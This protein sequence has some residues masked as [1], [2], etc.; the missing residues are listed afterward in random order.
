MIAQL[1]A[2]IADDCPN[3]IFSANHIRNSHVICCGSKKLDAV[4]YSTTIISSADVN[5]DKIKLSIEE[6]IASAPEF[7][8]YNTTMKVSNAVV[9]TGMDNVYVDCSGSTHTPQEENQTEDANETPHIWLYL[10][11]VLATITAVFVL[12]MFIT[13]FTVCLVRRCSKSKAKANDPR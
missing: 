10:F 4:I 7:H 11:I 5:M 2:W 13:L 8:Q 12:L 1:V 6:W 9:L 3:C